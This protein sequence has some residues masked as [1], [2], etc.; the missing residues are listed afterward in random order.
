[1][2]SSA[3][4]PNLNAAAMPVE[5]FYAHLRTA[6]LLAQVVADNSRLRREARSSAPE[7][8]PMDLERIAREAPLSKIVG[9]KLRRR[10]VPKSPH[11]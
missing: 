7:T 8:A 5:E 1:M 11:R 9:A 3:R 2:P 10:L 4:W 6:R